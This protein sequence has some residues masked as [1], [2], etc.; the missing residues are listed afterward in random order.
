MIG[1]PFAIN[2]AAS[3][4]VLEGRQVL[5]LRGIVVGV[6]RFNE[7]PPGIVFD[8]LTLNPMDVARLKAAPTEGTA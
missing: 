8:G 2:V 5:T 4:R 7:C 1:L 3:D 6:S